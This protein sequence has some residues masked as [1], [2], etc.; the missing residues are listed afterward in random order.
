MANNVPV[1]EMNDMVD[2][3]TEANDVDI[4]VTSDI[5]IDEYSPDEDDR[6]ALE[7][8]K[9]GSKCFL[10]YFIYIFLSRHTNILQKFNLLKVL[11]TNVKRY[12]SI[13]LLALIC[14]LI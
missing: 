14:Y 6:A 8:L 11:L 2:T 9:A 3:M 5:G 12:S 4:R 7:F 1:A 10:F 13:N